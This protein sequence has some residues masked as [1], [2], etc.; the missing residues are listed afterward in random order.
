MPPD[1]DTSPAE[2]PSGS[3]SRFSLSL[4]ALSGVFLLV[5]VGWCVGLLALAVW[6][7]TKIF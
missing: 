4:I 5:G 6:V 1:A 3:E 2:K 7:L